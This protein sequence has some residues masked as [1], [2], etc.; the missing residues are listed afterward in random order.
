MTDG[1]CVGCG[2]QTL[3]LVECL[4]TREYLACEACCE[5]DVPLHC[6]TCRDWER[7]MVPVGSYLCRDSGEDRPGTALELE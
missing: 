5:S 2:L 3:N 6:G 1:R 4:C 7:R